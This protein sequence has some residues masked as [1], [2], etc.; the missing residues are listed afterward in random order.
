M[1]FARALSV[2]VPLADAAAAFHKLKFGTGYA[3]PDDTGMLEGQFEAQ[4]PEVLQL[5]GE[6]VNNEFKTMLAYK[7]YA[8]SLRGTE[9]GSIAE[10][11]EEHAE[12]ELE[13]AEFLMK[14]M[15]VLGGAIQLND[16]PA[17]PASTDPV[18]II[19]TMIRMEQEGIAKWKAFHAI[20]GDNPTK[21]KVEEFMTTEQHHLDE[22][23]QMLPY[24]AR[25]SVVTGAPEANTLPANPMAGG[26]PPD[27]GAMPS[28][29]LGQAKSAAL[30]DWGQK[31]KSV[32]TGAAKAAPEVHVPLRP[33]DMGGK[34]TEEFV[35]GFLKKNPGAAA[36]GGVKTMGKSGSAVF[37]EV[38]QEKRAYYRYHDPYG[39]GGYGGYYNVDHRV[40]DEA[41][42]KGEVQRY[43]GQLERHGGDRAA[44]EQELIGNKRR[45]GAVGGALGF[46]GLGALL[47]V[48][49]GAA[50]GGAKGAII[51]TL[52]GAGLGGLAGHHLGKG[53]GEQS[54]N[55]I[56]DRSYA[57]K[58]REKAVAA[59][60]LAAFKRKLAEGTNY[61]ALALAADK[62]KKIVPKPSAFVPSVIKAKSLLGKLASKDPPTDKEL[63]Q[64][65]E[66]RATASLAARA[67]AH[68]G[69]RG[70]QYGDVAGRIL[71]A[72][73]GAAVGA[74]LG[75]EGKKM[76]AGLGSAAL[77]QHLGGKAGKVL[78]RELD[79]RKNKLGSA[80]EKDQSKGKFQLNESFM[81]DRH[82]HPQDKI[83]HAYHEL[84]S[85]GLDHDTSM[86]SAR[87]NAYFM[88]LMGTGHDPRLDD[89]GEIK[90]GIHKSFM[91]DVNVDDIK[92]RY[93]AKPKVASVKYAFGDPMAQLQMEQQGEQA[94]EQGAADYFAQKARQVA[95]EK[96]QMEAQLQQAMAESQQKDQQLQMTQQTIQSA[97]DSSTKALMQAVQ[98]NG[99]AIKQRQVA[100]DTTISMDK[101]R[102]SLRELADGGG[103][104]GGPGDMSGGAGEAQGATQATAGG[105]VGG[106][107][108]PG[109]EQAG[110]A[111]QA[112]TPSAGPG[113]APPEGENQPETRSQSPE[114]GSAAPATTTDQGQ[115][116]GG[117]GG[118]GKVSI[119]VGS[120]ALS[121]FAGKARASGGMLSHEL[122][123]PTYQIGEAISRVAKKD[124]HWQKRLP[125]VAA[126]KA[127]GQDIAVTGMS[128][129]GGSSSPA[130]QKAKAPFIRPM[131]KGLREY[132]PAQ[133]DHIDNVIAA[134]V[135]RAAKRKTAGFMDIA[136]EVG[137]QGLEQ[138]KKRGPYALAGGAMAG[139]AQMLSNMGGSEKAQKRV[140]KLEGTQDGSFGQAMQLAAAKADSER[141][142]LG[143]AHPIAS[144]AGAALG[145]AMLGGAIGPSW[146]P[147]LKNIGKNIRELA[148]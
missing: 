146:G 21:Y 102:Q 120:T 35:A 129:L 138:V 43:L 26:G 3:P 98:A 144:T 27:E 141:Q 136:K 20:C 119:K 123:G 105:P 107:A 44:M 58:P 60:K 10:E 80:G 79:S 29:D 94:A 130:I 126:E 5:L 124:H 52:A 133:A 113:A 42:T 46:G 112:A 17:P 38:L 118:Q 40:G 23:W 101:L 97:T 134:N 22:L 117:E 135:E 59:E 16:I 147:K 81:T 89:K 77:G 48:H 110:P 8:E 62:A 140:K 24:E 55:E 82:V 65:G 49:T 148:G 54:A 145:G 39:Y 86:G 127:R 143:A 32:F 2:D 28:P 25:A 56:I 106:D 15:S 100:A 37:Q 88:H 121:R 18:D 92:N 96:Q 4:P 116:G 30:K 1:T 125:A 137:K 87:H 34:T 109:G 63:R 47:G 84:R 64:A 73:G 83:R 36:G 132:N 122:S 91:G 76:L 85:G 115:P 142:Q 74:K 67:K 71:G 69:T 11:F 95:Q 61:E 78:G 139:G 90:G 103:S 45:A 57:S 104:P 9:R 41:V 128:T 12:A 114:Q 51:G 19:K 50:L 99:D 131:R 13:H 14:R 75:P 70:E 72:A 7:T 68:A 66:N 53:M 108:Q 93:D 33:H 6:M 111:G 31:L